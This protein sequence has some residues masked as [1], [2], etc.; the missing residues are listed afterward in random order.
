M[1]CLTSRDDAASVITLADPMPGQ[2][3]RPPGSVA[4]G[5]TRPQLSGN[6]AAQMYTTLSTEL[7][8]AVLSEDLDAG[9]PPQSLTPRPR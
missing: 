3:V 1:P 4:L 5:P 8:G 9:P 2:T 7:G 6:C